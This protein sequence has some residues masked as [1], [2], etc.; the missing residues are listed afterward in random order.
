[1]GG[2]RQGMVLLAEGHFRL[3][4]G[5]QADKVTLQDTS[6]PSEARRAPPKRKRKSLSPA[7]YL[8]LPK[9]PLK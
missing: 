3:T 4:G 6:E 7:G 9:A 5:P 2:N 8:R 1:M